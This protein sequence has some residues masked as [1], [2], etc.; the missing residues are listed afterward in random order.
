MSHLPYHQQ[1]L[2]FMIDLAR[3]RIEFLDP[4][5]RFLNYFDSPYF[6]FVLIPVI[7]IGFSYQWGLRIFYWATINNL[8][9]SFVKN[10]FAWPRPSTDL[11]ELGLFTPSS[12]GFPS[13]GAQM[14]MLLG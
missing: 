14:S 3:S 2:E 6:F 8:I 5:F 10:A 4:F 9:N 12:H 13:G 11:P 1:Q 7:W